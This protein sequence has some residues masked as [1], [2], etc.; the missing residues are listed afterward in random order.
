MKRLGILLAMLFFLM[1]FLA[2]A[3]EEGASTAGSDNAAVS[4]A[5][6]T[7]DPSASGAAEELLLKAL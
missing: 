2:V 1:P 6:E 7:E 4:T 3:Q 5:T